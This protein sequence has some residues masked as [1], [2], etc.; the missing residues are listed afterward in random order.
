[1]TNND[2]LAGSD[3]YDILGGVQEDLVEQL[4]QYGRMEQAELLQVPGW[5]AK[6]ARLLV[7]AA[8]E[9]A[10]LRQVA[11]AVS[12]G[13]DLYYLKQ[14]RPSVGVTLIKPKP[15]DD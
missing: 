3:T 2:P 15:G 14:C 12:D 5:A 1:M 4:T 10:R 11:G 13:P 7:D 6:V 8:K 9:I